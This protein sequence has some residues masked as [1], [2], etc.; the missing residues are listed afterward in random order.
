MYTKDELAALKKREQELVS[1][2]ETIR[3]ELRKIR[4]VFYARNAYEK[5]YGEIKP[6]KGKKTPE[7][8]REYNRIK[9][10]ESRAR[11]KKEA[12]K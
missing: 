2:I 4:R 1:Q 11:R 10:R 7:E 3:E 5:T 12:A 8:L 6:Y 9:Q